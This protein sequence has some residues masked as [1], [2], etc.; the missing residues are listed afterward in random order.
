MRK[1]AAVRPTSVAATDTSPTS[2][3]KAIT[4]IQIRRILFTSVLAIQL[5][6]VKKFREVDGNANASVNRH[7]VV[8]HQIG[9]VLKGAI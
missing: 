5:A 8:W 1:S 2:A 9:P 3:A 6:F 7:W 4:M